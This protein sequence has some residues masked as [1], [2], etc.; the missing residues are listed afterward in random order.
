[1]IAFTHVESAAIDLNTLDNAGYVNVAVRVGISV[2]IRG[3][4]VRHKVAADLNELSYR[5]S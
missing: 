4:V 3:K 1:M 2:R 5:L